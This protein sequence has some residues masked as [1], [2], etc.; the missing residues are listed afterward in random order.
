[1]RMTGQTGK[2]GRVKDGVEERGEDNNDYK[3]EDSEDGG[4]DRSG[5]DK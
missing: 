4:E 2:G 5:Y 1:M 3:T